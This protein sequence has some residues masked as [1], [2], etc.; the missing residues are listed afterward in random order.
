MSGPPGGP[1][2]SFQAER[3]YEPPT[4]PE[5]AGDLPK[6][7]HLEVAVDDLEAAVDLVVALAAA[8]LRGSPRTEMSTGSGSCSTRLANHSAS[9]RSSPRP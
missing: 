1:S 4:W 8:S 7:M 9:A 2:V 3:W 6:M 5:V